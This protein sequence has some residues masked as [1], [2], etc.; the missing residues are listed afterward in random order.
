ML[1]V[2][3]RGGT[4]L[5]CIW[6]QWSRSALCTLVFPASRPVFPGS[7]FQVPASRPPAALTRIKVWKINERMKP[8]WRSWVNAG[9]ITLT[10]FVRVGNRSQISDVL[11]ASFSLILAGLMTAARITLRHW[12]VFKSHLCVTSFCSS[13][14]VEF[15]IL[16][17]EWCS[18]FALL[19]VLCVWFKKDGKNL[20]NKPGKSSIVLKRW[21]VVST[22]SLADANSDCVCVLIPETRKLPVPQPSPF[23]ADSSCSKVQKPLTTYKRVCHRCVSACLKEI[24]SAAS[25]LAPAKAE[26][27]LLTSFSEVFIQSYAYFGVHSEYSTDTHT[28]VV[29][30]CC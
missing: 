3:N 25:L 21:W 5:R 10:P 6:E 26:K 30:L 12:M 2:W 13:V 4:V 7:R 19:C 16:I 23:P 27:A 29:N 11:K 22:L 18:W 14:R 15:C 24:L 9:V 17:H 20:N 28:D 8:F 1:E